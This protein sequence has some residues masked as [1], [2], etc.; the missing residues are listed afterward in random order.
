LIQSCYT[1]FFRVLFDFTD[2]NECI[3]NIDTRKRNINSNFDENKKEHVLRHGI[4]Y[5]IYFR[6]FIQAFAKFIY[7]LHHRRIIYMIKRK[8][9]FFSL[10]KKKN[11]ASES[12]IN[13]SLSAE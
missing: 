11:T 7:S 12:G 4:I 13:N 3:E 8:A 10:N 2:T 5:Y 9:F 6:K 1:Y